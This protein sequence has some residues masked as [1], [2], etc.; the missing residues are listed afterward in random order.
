MAMAVEEN[1]GNGRTLTTTEIAAFTGNN[2][3]TLESD[4]FRKYRGNRNNVVRGKKE[5]GG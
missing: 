5:K 4:R 1:A 2:Y 3:S